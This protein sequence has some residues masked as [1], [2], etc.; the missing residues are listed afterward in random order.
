MHLDLLWRLRPQSQAG[1]PVRLVQPIP[2]ADTHPRTLSASPARR[3]QASVTRNG[4]PGSALKLLVLSLWLGRSCLLSSKSSE[5]WR[6][7]Y[8]PASVAP[9]RLKTNRAASRP[10]G[11]CMCGKSL[12]SGCHLFPEQSEVGDL[13]P[14][15][16]TSCLELSLRRCGIHGPHP[17]R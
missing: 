11:F 13:Q 5:R 15:S 12:S 10:P 3:P 4:C 17:F 6:P 8:A 7:S 2:A 1:C 16:P 9:L 14:S